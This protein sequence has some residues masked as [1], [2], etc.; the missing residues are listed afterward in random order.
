MTSV[1]TKRSHDKNDRSEKKLDM[2]VVLSK[3]PP[4]LIRE[5]R[6]EVKMPDR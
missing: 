2:K 3:I 1:V 4:Q 5:N 6:V